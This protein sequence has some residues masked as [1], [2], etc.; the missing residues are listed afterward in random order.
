MDRRD[1]H[2]RHVGKTFLGAFEQADAVEVGHHQVGE[3]QFEY[4]AGIEQRESF[5][6]GTGLLPGV[7]GGG[8]NGAD[9]LADCLF[10]VDYENAVRH[11]GLRMTLRLLSAILRYV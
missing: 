2:D 4:L 7:A 3:H 9:N 10:V 1:H 8:K 6:A 11:D 5:H